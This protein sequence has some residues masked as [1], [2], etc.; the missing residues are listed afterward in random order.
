MRK[1]RENN[2]KKQQH[3]MHGEIFLEH[4][5]R[6]KIKQNTYKLAHQNKQRRTR[7]NR[8]YVIKG[9]TNSKL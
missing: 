5:L 1:T 3:D 4:N 2:S 6:E 9:K 7:L 8:Y